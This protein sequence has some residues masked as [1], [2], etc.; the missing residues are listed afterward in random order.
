MAF[1]FSEIMVHWVSFRVKFS[2]KR[3]GQFR[4]SWVGRLFVVVL[5]DDFIALAGHAST[6][7]LQV[8]PTHFSLS[9]FIVESLS[10]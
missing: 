2:L 3:L 4:F 8:L 9:N 5:F 7:M 6:Q 1:V 10:M